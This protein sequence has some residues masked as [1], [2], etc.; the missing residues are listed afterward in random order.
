MAIA[1]L[2]PGCDADYSVPENLAGKSIRCKKCGETIAVKPSRVKSRVNGDEDDDRPRRAI[3]RHRDEDD[4]EFTPAR[5]NS[6]NTPIL[7]AGLLALLLGG[8]AGGY[9]LFADTKD[10]P[11]P[12][13][14]VAKNE[15]GDP[16]PSKP[17]EPKVNE[18]KPDEPKAEDKKPELKSDTKKADDTAPKAGDQKSEN[19]PADQ[20]APPKKKGENVI[21][22]TTPNPNA[23]APQAPTNTQSPGG[24]LSYADYIQGN[25]PSLV[26]EMVKKS[27]VLFKVEGGEGSGWFGLEPNLVITNAHVLGMLGRNPKEPKKIEIV[28]N[29]GTNDERI[30]PHANIKIL[31]VDG[32][33]DL[34]L[35]QIIN[36][37]DLPPPLKV[38][39]AEELEI[40]QR[41]RTFGFP[42][43]SSLRDEAGERTKNPEMSVRPTTVT[44]KRHDDYGVLRTVQIEGGVTNGNSGG[45]IVDAEGVVRTVVVRGYIN[46]GRGEIEQTQA[47]SI[48][49]EWVVGLAAG[50]I[51]D[52]VYGEP[53]KNGDKVK[54]PVKVKML[55][56]LKRVTKVG[57]RHWIGTA[58]KKNRSPGRTPPSKIEGDTEHKEV[59]LKY[60]PETK[61]ATGY[62]DTDP[63][64]VEKTCYWGQPFY[65]N[66][67]TPLQY[68]GGNALPI[69]NFLVEEIEALLAPKVRNTTRTLT[70]SNS[71]RMV[72]LQKGQDDFRL[73]PGE[74]L[75]EVVMK[76]TVLGPD[77]QDPAS[78]ARLR[79]QY[80]KFTP[81]V[82]VG[83]TEVDPGIIVSESFTNAFKQIEAY[84]WVNKNGEVYKTK[85]NALALTGVPQQGVATLLSISDG[86]L[87][88]LRYASIALPNEQVKPGY[89]W[90]SDKDIIVSYGIERLSTRNPPRPEDIKLL[91]ARFSLKYEYKYLGVRTRE[92]R[93]EAVVEVEGNV[94]PLKGKKPD[95]AKGNVKGRAIVELDTG[96]VLDSV[97]DFEFEVDVSARGTQRTLVGKKVAKLKRSSSGS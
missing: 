31:A 48:P 38:R 29:S 81:K 95:S 72:V 46:L 20:P 97:Q 26:Q 96:T 33:I 65:A 21:G 62:L 45:P 92:G 11:K 8:A 28:I 87:D 85:T 63:I 32:K 93:K 90:K 67:L 51:D 56:P 35:L 14:T 80:E 55:D 30:I 50:R 16:Q 22:N 18:K 86:I 39:P 1:I 44:A 13:P 59:I 57:I 75:D 88:S 15:G 84:G 54:I 27:T 64:T 34:A 3:S 74:R 25:M 73:S 17:E 76:E 23:V 66:A 10:D 69:E 91:E 89:K 47:S 58:N 5:K 4:E 9:F 77:T 52:V 24:M 53:I 70:L 42:L 19:K 60:D 49:S 12:N 37:K 79:L 41:L 61:I 36:E 43:G 2:C 78:I 6:S 94:M 68:E 83:S 82:L 71:S 7:I 40:S